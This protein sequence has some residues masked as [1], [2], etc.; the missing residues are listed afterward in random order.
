MKTGI[1]IPI[2]KR[3]RQKHSN[4]VAWPLSQGWNVVGLGFGPVKIN[5]VIS[6]IF[7]TLFL[8]VQHSMWD[9]IVLRPGVEPV[10]S[11]SEL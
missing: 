8:V 2:S 6:L 4:V 10:P 7:F 9:L 3:M 5:S 1:F 11:A